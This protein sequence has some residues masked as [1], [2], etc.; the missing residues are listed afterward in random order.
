M[1]FKLGENCRGKKRLDDIQNVRMI[2][3]AR[4]CII[5]QGREKK[6]TAGWAGSR[7]QSSNAENRSL[8]QG[9]TL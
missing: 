1:S 7:T 2:G 6:M 8:S 4:F 3:E 9:S 5:K